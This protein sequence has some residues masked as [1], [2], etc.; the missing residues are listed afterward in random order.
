M[1]ADA[2]AEQGDI[3]ERGWSAAAG[4]PGEHDDQRGTGHDFGDNPWAVSRG[5]V[6]KLGHAI[7]E[8]GDAGGQQGEPAQV[9]LG[10]GGWPGRREDPHRGE[11]G[12]QAHRHVDVED[13]PPARVLDYRSADN[14]AQGG[15]EQHRQAEQAH[16]PSH[17]ARAG[18]LGQGGLPD[19][20]EQ[21]GTQALDDPESDQCADRP[22]ET[23]Q[24]RTEHERGE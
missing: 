5:V 24:D 23:G 16:H 21:A 15:D 12:N 9:Q 13:P 4:M 7:E 14:R 19:R 3:E 20:H 1:V 22:G 11:D 8:G 18:G 17:P 10:G 6:A 2:A